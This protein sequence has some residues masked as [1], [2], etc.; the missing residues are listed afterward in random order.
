[1]KGDI[2]CEPIPLSCKTKHSYK[3]CNIQESKWVRENS[4]ERK[5]ERENEIE[6]GKMSAKGGNHMIKQKVTD[7]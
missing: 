2:C 5:N 6:R 3:I 4:I 1:M 7:C